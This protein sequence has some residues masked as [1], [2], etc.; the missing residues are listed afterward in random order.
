MKLQ[1]VSF[2]GSVLK[3]GVGY[4]Q[5]AALAEALRTKTTLTL[6]DLPFND[7]N[8]AGAAALAEGLKTNTT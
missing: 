8:A 3:R 7:L 6:L 1:R 4:G 5:V 2:S